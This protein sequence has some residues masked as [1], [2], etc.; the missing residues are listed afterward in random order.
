ME[1]SSEK[2]K[3]LYDMIEWVFQDPKKIGDAISVH[4][5]MT[6]WCNYNCPYC[7]QQGVKPNGMDTS[8]EKLEL[9]SSKLRKMFSGK[10]VNLV[11]LGGEVSFF[12]LNKICEILFKDNNCSGRVMLITNLSAPAE[13]YKNFL[14]QNYENLNFTIRASYQWVEINGFISKVKEINNKNLSICDIVVDD[15]KTIE[16]ILRVKNIFEKNNIGCAFTTGRI[17]MTNS[18]KYFN[19]SPEIKQFIEH[20]ANNVSTK[21]L[22]IK[23]RNID[24]PIMR[25][26]SFVLATNNLLGNNGA[27]FENFNCLPTLQIYPNGDVFNGMCSENKK[28]G[29][30]LDENSCDYKPY[31]IK[32]SGKYGCSHCSITTLYTENT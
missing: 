4:W 25:N 28:I 7:I 16:E 2:A 14:Q 17:P 15:T 8:Q 27:K 32:C 26:R 10:K 18:T 5:N 22:K 1:F 11:I 6:Y 31:I 12:N 30:L 20:S 9:F 21:T 19:V 13:V 3:K 24:K 23:F 29:N